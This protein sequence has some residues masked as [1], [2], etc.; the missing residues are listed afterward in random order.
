MIRICL[1]IIAA[2]TIMPFVNA[3]DID[4]YITDAK[5]NGQ[6][7]NILERDSKGAFIT[8]M[9]DGF[10]VCSEMEVKY[11]KA[12]ASF[13]VRKIRR[14]IVKFIS[15]SMPEGLI[16]EDAIAYIDKFYTDESNLS[17]PISS[18]YLKYVEL[19]KP[20]AKKNE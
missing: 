13:K 12:S 4:S 10:T 3:D 11:F 18:A 9:G 5:A 17:V 7:W 6:Y 14:D 15:D 19:Q 16:I 2:L 20:S 1:F 8:G